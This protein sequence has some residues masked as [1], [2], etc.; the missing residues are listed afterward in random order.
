MFNRSGVLGVGGPTS[1]KLV[2]MRQRDWLL[3]M[4]LIAALLA[5]QVVA[6]SVGRVSVS[7]DSGG[8]VLAARRVARGMSRERRVGVRFWDLSVYDLARRVA[9]WVG[10]LASAANRDN[11]GGYWAGWV[12]QLCAIPPPVRLR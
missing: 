10:L 1:R 12:P 9:T 6:T 2:L 11:V 4:V 5:Q 8:V 3:V 7:N